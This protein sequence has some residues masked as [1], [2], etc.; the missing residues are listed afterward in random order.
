MYRDRE[1]MKAR[2][3]NRKKG[4]GIKKKKEGEEE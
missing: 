2:G 3:E 4:G 1:G